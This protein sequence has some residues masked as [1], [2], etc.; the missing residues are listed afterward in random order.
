MKRFLALCLCLCMIF[1]LTPAVYAARDVSYAQTLAQDLKDLG[2]FRG[3]SETDFA[4]SRPAT[5]TEALV[6]LLRLL[7]QEN[8]AL[9]FEGT[10]PFTDVPGWADRYVA[11]AWENG[12]TNGVS[13]TTFGTSDATCQM[14]ATF[15]LRALGYNDARGDFTWNDP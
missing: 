7:G 13:A 8:Q 5:R 12:L 9:S 4:L 6:M 15:L 2:L 11:Y 3:V 14:Y 1:G 10:H